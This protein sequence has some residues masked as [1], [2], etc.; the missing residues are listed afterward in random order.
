[1]T[2]L[3]PASSLIASAPRAA[4]RRQCRHEALALHDEV[5]QRVRFGYRRKQ[6]AEIEFASRERSRLLRREHFAQREQHAGTRRLVGFEQSGQHATVVGKRD[7]ADTQPAA[8][9]GGH[10]AQLEHRALELAHGVP[11]FL[12]ESR[13]GWREL[14]PPAVTG[15]K[16]HAD[17]F[18][19]REDGAR[20]RWL[21]D[22]Q[23]RGRPAEMQVLGHGHEIPQLPK[24][25]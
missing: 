24:I 6:Q 18:L 9:A 8:L 23:R 20:E 5:L 3:S 10:A 22:V 2:K 15:E 25:W 1:M 12:K 19:E 21:R 7:E 16:R 14:D 17:A 11:R 4:A 13:T